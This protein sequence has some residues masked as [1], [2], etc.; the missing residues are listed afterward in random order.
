M[1]KIFLHYSFIFVVSELI[2]N[3]ELC[4]E[5]TQIRR[6]VFCVLPQSLFAIPF[7]FVK[8]S[9]AQEDI[10]SLD[11][12]PLEKVL[13]PKFVQKVRVVLEGCR[14]ERTRAAPM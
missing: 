6:K 3:S 14:N 8:L 11:E 13:M 1:V 2:V 12:C 5:F 4:H 10:S 7:S 9:V